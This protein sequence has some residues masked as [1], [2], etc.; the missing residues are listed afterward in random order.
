MNW[1]GVCRGAF[2]GL[3]GSSPSCFRATSPAVGGLGL[4]D[5]VSV[6]GRRRSISVSSH[7]P[8]ST[9]LGS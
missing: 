7:G 8:I 1:S 5:R 6:S 3:D 4:T 2:G 9:A